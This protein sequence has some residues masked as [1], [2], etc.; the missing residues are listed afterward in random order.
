VAGVHE[1]VSMDRVID[2]LAGEDR[3]FAERLGG[4]HDADSL[5]EAE[6]SA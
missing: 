2:E 6:S 1:V 3:W 5:S 4:D